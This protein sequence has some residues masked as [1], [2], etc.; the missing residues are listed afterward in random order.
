MHGFGVL[1]FEYS[2]IK[3]SITL[4]LNWSFKLYVICGIPIVLHTFLASVFVSILQHEPANN[5]SVIPITSY[6]ISFKSSADTELSTP[7][8]IPNKTLFIFSSF[9]YLIFFYYNIFFCN[10]H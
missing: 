2:S 10:L 5:S 1:C 6:P 8:L 3:L 9:F 7:P 4:H